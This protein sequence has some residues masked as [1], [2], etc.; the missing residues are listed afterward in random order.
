MQNR[1]LSRRRFLGYSAGAVAGLFTAGLPRFA[2]AQ[3][4]LS[5]QGTAEL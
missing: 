3:E 5:F 4:A 2:S 1:K